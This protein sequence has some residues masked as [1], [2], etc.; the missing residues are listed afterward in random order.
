MGDSTGRP[1]GVENSP[2][3]RQDRN[4]NSFHHQDTKTPRSTKK[5]TCRSLRCSQ[6]LSLTFPLVILGALGVLVVSSVVGCGGKAAPA[7]DGSDAVELVETIDIWSPPEAPAVSWQPEWSVDP[8]SMTYSTEYVNAV[9]AAVDDQG[10]TVVLSVGVH[11]TYWP[12]KEQVKPWDSIV[13][14]VD[15]EGFVAF[16]N[17]LEGLHVLFDAEAGSAR[18]FWQGPME[19]SSG[20][21]VEVLFD[22]HLDASFTEA[23]LF[24]I[25]LTGADLGLAHWPAFLGLA[26][27]ESVLRLGDEAP[28]GITSL[29]GELE[30]GDL[31]YLEGPGLAFRYN[32][33]CV[34]DPVEGWVYL[35]FGGHALDSEGAGAMLEDLIASSMKLEV[36]LQGDQ[37]LEGNVYGVP[38]KFILGGGTML[39]N[40]PVALGLAVNDR[41]LVEV[42]DGNGNPVWGLREIFTP[43]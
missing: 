23:V 16:G 29:A 7:V 37:V 43:Q 8:D 30:H 6:L 2:P 19:S 10:R 42:T 33:L 25:G 21:I 24:G 17:P 34:A 3:R 1:V 36:T 5:G 39:V 28:A 40:D 38:E 4:V 20:E 18:F 41:Q 27:G 35:N 31:T 14:A 12:Y 22:L 32:Y 26:E 15:G 9:M 13:L 11:G